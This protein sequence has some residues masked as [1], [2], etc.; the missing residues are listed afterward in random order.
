MGPCSRRIKLI[1]SRFLNLTRFV[2][3]QSVAEVCSATDRSGTPNQ[4][5]ETLRSIFGIEFPSHGEIQVR[6]GWTALVAFMAT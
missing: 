4:I 6:W 3:L 1:Y 5:L 2:T